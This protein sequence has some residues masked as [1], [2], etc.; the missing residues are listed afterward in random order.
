MNFTNKLQIIYRTILANYV[1]DQFII[2]LSSEEIFSASF[3]KQFESYTKND[4]TAILHNIQRMEGK[5]IS[6]DGDL[7]IFED[8]E[9]L[10]DQA[11]PNLNEAFKFRMINNFQLIENTV[12]DLH[13]I[14]S[15]S[16]EKINSYL[17]S[18]YKKNLNLDFLKQFNNVDAPTLAQLELLK[19][20]KTNDA[21]IQEL[22]TDF[23][24]MFIEMKTQELIANT[25]SIKE[26]IQFK[27][28]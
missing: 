15:L 18:H 3:Y 17:D 25:I 24:P 26:L 22:M 20:D 12:N 23:Y 11:I 6:I 7:F 28:D 5:G 1:D 8:F 21:M 14:D 19:K 9:D 10:L 2:K 13:Y 4:M 27:A 16:T